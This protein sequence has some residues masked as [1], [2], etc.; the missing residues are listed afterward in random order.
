MN[1]LRKISVM[2][3]IAALMVSMLLAAVPVKAL[4]PPT[5]SPN[6]GP[7]GTKVTISGNGASAGGKVETY[8]EN[9]GG[10]K[11]NETYADGTGNYQMVV[12]IPEDTAGTH[13]IIV[14]DVSTGDTQGVSFTIKPKIT[15]SPLRGIP[16]DEITVSGNG[17]GALQN[18]TLKLY[19]TTHI[20]V[21]GTN[22]TVTP[23]PPKTDSNGT[24]SATFKIPS[25]IKYGTYT[26]NATDTANNHNATTIIV[27]AAITLS[28]TS[29]SAGSIV[30]ISGRGFTA[31]KNITVTINVSTTV[32]TVP[33]VSQIKTGSDGTFSGQIII[34]TFPVGFAT[35][36]ATDGTY[37]ATASFKVTGNTKITLT[38]TSGPPGATVT[39]TGV[40]F[41]AIADT[42]VTVKFGALTVATLYTDASGSFTGTFEVPSLPTTSYTVTATDKYGLVNSTSF[43]IALV[44]I[45]LTP[46]SAACGANV[47][48]AGY[49]FSGANANITIGNLQVRKNVPVADLSAG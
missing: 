17:F 28:P 49:G 9:L 1:K 37:W 4:N 21:Q 42:P 10:T 36:N 33:Q 23:V 18:V 27:G 8:W 12:Y 29:G 3:I 46:S 24:F 6:S 30:S 13:Y 15:V 26:I 16:G 25:S 32:K 35:I 45:V 19:N 47:T 22:L 39:I 20:W 31:N 7:V 34:P 44:M 48:V 38:P 5:A 2:T 43:T 14:R 41:T 11:L 40:N